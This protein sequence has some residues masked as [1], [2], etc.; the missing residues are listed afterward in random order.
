[1]LERKAYKTKIASLEAEIRRLNEAL[2]TCQ[3]KC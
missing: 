2:L 3:G 1:M